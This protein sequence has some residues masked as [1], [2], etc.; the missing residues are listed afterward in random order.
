MDTWISPVVVVALAGLASALI[1]NWINRRAELKL[2]K[3]DHLHDDRSRLLNEKQ[4]AYSRLLDLG[5]GVQE[6]AVKGVENRNSTTFFSD[7]WSA[8]SQ[9]KLVSSVG[10]R[11]AIDAYAGSIVQSSGSSVGPAETTL[12]PILSTELSV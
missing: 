4:A 3:I 1:T 11:E 12:I 9:A 6:R 2:R 8:A 5:R 10:T 7:F